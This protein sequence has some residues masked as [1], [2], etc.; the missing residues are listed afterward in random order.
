[1]SKPYRIFE[2]DIFIDDL[3]TLPG[4]I[5]EKMALKLR[6]HVYPLLKLQPY[7]G[8]N[9]KKLTGYDPPTWRYRIGDYR[10]V[11]EIQDK[12]VHILVIAIGDRKE[13]YR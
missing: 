13:V 7:Y 2:T 5:A 10:L 11:C 3:E 6:E 1:M 4:N 8:N 12:S 9:I